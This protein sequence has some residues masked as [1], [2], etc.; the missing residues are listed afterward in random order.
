MTSCTHMH[1]VKTYSA[2]L[3]VDTPSSFYPV[4]TFTDRPY[5]TPGG[6]LSLLGTLSGTY[7]LVGIT[8]SIF[9]DKKLPPSTSTIHYTRL[10]YT[11]YGNEDE[12]DEQKTQ[13]NGRVFLERPGPRRGIALRGN[14]MALQE[15]TPQSTRNRWYCDFIAPLNGYEANSGP[16]EGLSVKTVPTNRTVSF[17][18][19]P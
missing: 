19:F 9:A 1:S 2:C 4:L 3:G 6:S 16:M 15:L 12:G 11:S 7:T 8:T 10:Y 13:K 14:G 17:F 18:F 5:L